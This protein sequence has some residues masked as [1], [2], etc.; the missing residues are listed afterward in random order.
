MAKLNGKK[1]ISVIGLGVVGL[2]TAVGFALKGHKVIGIDID[3]EKVRQI[4]EGTCPIYEEGLSSALKEVNLVATAD[5]GRAL[6][7]DITFLC[8]GTPPKADG[9]I[10]L[11]FLEEPARQ[12]RAVLKEKIGDH[13]VVV[14]ST[15]VP[16]TTE[17]VIVPVLNH[18]EKVGICVNPEFLREGTAVEDF[19]KPSRIVIG[20]KEEKWGDMLADIYKDYNAPILRTDFS[21]AEMIK[22]ASNAYLAM[23]VSFINEIGNICKSMG[24]DV[25]EVAKGMGLDS[26]IG[27]DYLNAGIGFGGFC[28]PKDLSALISSAKDANYRARILE[29]V[30]RLNLNQPERMLTILKKHIQV[31]KGAT[32]GILGLA[33]KP[34]TDDIRESKAIEIIHALQ[35]EGAKVTAYDPQAMP[36]FRKVFPDSVKY[37]TADEVL[38]ADAV[39]ILTEWDDFNNLDYRGKIVIDGRRV[40]KAREARVYEGICW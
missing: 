6:D 33:F 26:R 19:I 14:R 12:L 21:T 10:D 25:Y 2:T 5:H 23:R 11:F 29:E 39:L 34:G 13:L 28:L 8:G 20:E 27:R 17:Q 32:I 35:E 4:N 37:M 38:K 1:T 16:G 24:M 30:Q 36:N 9:S 40:P 15:V 22:Q 18:N 3:V 7:S 31:L